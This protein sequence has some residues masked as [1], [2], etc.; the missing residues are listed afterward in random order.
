MTQKTATDQH[1]LSGFY[2]RHLKE[3]YS[4][5][6]FL[7]LEHPYAVLS[8]GYLCPSVIDVGTHAAL[9]L[10]LLLTTTKM[11]SILWYRRGV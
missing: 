11:A 1:T 4:S 2:R 7:I 10:R 5:L 3:N 8:L 6:V 9:D